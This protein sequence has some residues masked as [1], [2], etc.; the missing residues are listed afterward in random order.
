VIVMS[1]VGKIKSVNEFLSDLKDAVKDTSWPES[2][3][4]TLPWYAEAAGG[5]LAD[6][7]A[8]IK[9]ILKLYKTLT[10]INDPNDLGY[11]ACTL[12]FQRS[13]QQALRQLP[14]PR[15]DGVK[16]TPRP[17]ES[18]RSHDFAAF[19]FDSAKSHLF[20]TEARAA[21]ASFCHD[22]G[23]GDADTNRV[24]H[25]VDLRF[26]TNLRLIL[27]HR[28]TE[29]K[30][31][32][33]LRLIRE[34][35]PDRADLALARHAD[36]QRW[37]YEE[38]TVLG[39]PF[40]LQHVYVDTECGLLTWGQVRESQKRKSAGP[41]E[42]GGIN[43]FRDTEKEG[44]R[45]DLLDCVLGL[46]AD[47]T[48]RDAIIIQGYAGSGKTSLTLRLCQALMDAG[49]QPIRIELKNL[50]TSSTNDIAETL[51]AAVRISDDDYDPHAVQHDYGSGLFRRNDVFKQS[52][53]FRGT[54][55]SKYVLIL[56]AWDEISV[57]A[58]LGYQK[59]VTRLL[60]QVR[61][62]YL[63]SSRSLPVRVILS[64]RPSEAVAQAGF[65]HD[66]TRLLT[67]RPFRPDSLRLFH[68]RLV[69]ALRDRP[70]GVE[71]WLPWTLE[72][73]QGLPEVLDRYT[74]DFDKARAKERHQEPVRDQGSVEVLGLP[75][76]AHLAFR[77]MAEWPGDVGKIL[78][79]TTVLYR[80]L[81]DLV[82]KGAAKPAQT[83]IGTE[84][85]AHLRE[86]GPRDVDLRDLIRGTA[87]A[88]T[89]IGNENITRAELEARLDLREGELDQ[90]AGKLETESVLSRLMVSFFFKSG[91][92][93]GCEFSHKSFREYLFA[94][95]V[96]ETLK[97]FG[98]GTEPFEERDPK[99]YWKD[100]SRD[101]S[102]PRFEWSR[103]LA[104]LLGPK[105]ITWEVSRHI[106]HLI[107][108]EVARSWGCD[109]FPRVG[110]PTEPL[111]GR[112][113]WYR[114]RDGLADLWDW[115]GEGVHL[116]P[117]PDRVGKEKRLEFSDPLALDVVKNDRW[118]S[119]T[120]RNDPL[121]VPT[122]ITSIDAHLGDGLF[123]LC[124]DVHR[125][126]IEAELKTPGAGSAGP[127]DSG[128]SGPA[129]PRR[130]RRYQAVR[131]HEGHDLVAFAPS[132][133]D[134]LYFQAYIARVNAAGFLP[135]G[136]ECF[137]RSIRMSWDDLKQVIF[138]F[139]I[140]HGANLSGADLYGAGL[141]GAN[142]FGANLSGANLSGA[143]LYRANLGKANLKDA[144]LAEANLKDANL[145]DA[146]LEGAN[147]E[148]VFLDGANLSGANLSGASVPRRQLKRAIGVKTARNVEKAIFL[149]DPPRAATNAKDPKPQGPPEG[150][151]D[152]S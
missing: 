53:D 137:P 131:S 146:N 26:A 50:D 107:E 95:Q 33:F 130:L 23:L 34:D 85:S 143:G 108:W 24:T 20:Y 114:I 97:A 44:G 66:E 68:E 148:G 58:E 147:L 100:F 125:A 139:S 88:I 9:F 62:V 65:L 78:E 7:I 103:R 122:R 10:A 77:L 145:K 69:A 25:Q 141:Y 144:N 126:I 86:D 63:S 55:I 13:T 57:G 142:L 6:S 118:L 2:I 27:T 51:P 59:Q 21:L 41:G 4:K 48:F 133:S 93:L 54:T 75:L 43:P 96:V 36:Y 31:G 64:G 19:S 138:H 28:E 18:D 15:K 79:N 16:S 14:P 29:E 32:P 135:P 70:V 99:T 80:S 124:A 5:A 89:L 17:P 72:G 150:T 110:D 30:F 149:D 121:P 111:G 87:E 102:D 76:L 52:A 129:T 12:A 42:E 123:L 61:N 49:L 91:K 128:P 90:R 84:R 74:S 132:G 104:D 56:D 82:I 22:V 71:K 39:E 119:R 151:S 47:E 73:K 67:T 37:L 136:R 92:E 140:L 116:R 106:T 35:N 46:I 120:T 81:V 8:P 109:S 94:E 3:A 45:H 40:A 112:E 152:P 60:E 1:I 101:G 98:R 117:Q 83:R 38:R 127:G 11:L 113:P 115:W 134:P 105:W